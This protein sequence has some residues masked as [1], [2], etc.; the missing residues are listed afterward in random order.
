MYIH[1]LHTLQLR[2]LGSL[3]FPENSTSTAAH[4]WITLSVAFQTTSIRSNWFYSMCWAL[5]LLPT[6]MV[7]LSVSQ[8]HRFSLSMWRPL[9]WHALFSL[10]RPLKINHI[11]GAGAKQVGILVLFWYLCT[12]HCRSSVVDRWLYRLFL[13]RF[14][15]SK[16]RRHTQLLPIRFSFCTISF[17]VLTIWINVS[18]ASFFAFKVISCSAN[19]YYIFDVYVSILCKAQ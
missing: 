17:S 15:L 19:T 3:P 2:S 11:K 14:V 4:T 10:L 5:R 6:M 13:V 16:D 9:Q 18:A 7:P 1:T 8:L 12:V